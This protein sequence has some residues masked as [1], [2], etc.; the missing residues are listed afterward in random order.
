MLRDDLRNEGGVS[1]VGLPSEVL[2]GARPA[3]LRSPEFT[4]SYGGH[5][6]RGTGAKDGTGTPLCER[7][8]HRER[9][10]CGDRRVILKFRRS[11]N[12]KLLRRWPLVTAT[13]F[14]GTYRIRRDGQTKL[15]NHPAK[16]TQGPV[17]IRASR[18]AYELTSRTDP[19]RNT[20]FT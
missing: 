14:C 8:R 4:A 11:G 9:G 7:G 10:I 17:V 15:T 18:P 12:G 13:A 1:S 5:P 6:S 19:I 20:L 16:L 2:I 3:H